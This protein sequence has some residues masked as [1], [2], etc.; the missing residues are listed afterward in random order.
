MPLGERVALLL[1]AERALHATPSISV[2]RAWTDLWRTQKCFYSTT[3]SRIEQT[4]LQAGSGISALAIDGNDAQERSY[5]GD[6]G[7][8][9][10]GGWEVVEA[11]AL[12]ENAARI[13]EEATQ[14]LDAPQCPS[15]TCDVVLGGSQVSLQIHE[16]LG[17]AA[18]LDRIMGWEANFS[19]TSFLSPAQLGTLQY[20]SKH[21]TI[22]I[23]NTLPRGFATAGYDDEGSKS[24]TS[25]IVRDGV[26][27]GFEMSRDTART[28]G[29]V[30]NACVR[31]ES[32]Q[33]VPMIRMCNLNMLPGPS[34]SR[35]SSKASPTESIWNRTG[36]GRS[37]TTA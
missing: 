17:H 35:A 30:T 32:W 34:R 33:H 1:E 37:T 12:R 5:P 23:D 4:L 2:G 19:G 18:E 16:S 15:G 21:V 3:G 24:V 29:R 14:L 25:D 10:S 28:I 8:Y 7:L 9:Q 36:R 22:V 13:G 11:A 31:A 20:G 27:V 26:L 6:I